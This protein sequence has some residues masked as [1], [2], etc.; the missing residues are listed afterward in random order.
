M[1]AQVFVAL[2]ANEAHVLPKWRL[3]VS[4]ANRK[5]NKMTTRQPARENGEA[6][7]VHAASPFWFCCSTRTT[8][9]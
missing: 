5:T 1:P 3:M 2:L 9:A 8:E 7:E 6:Y 4:A